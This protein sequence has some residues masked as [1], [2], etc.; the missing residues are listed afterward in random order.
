[1]L[2]QY[3]YNAGTSS[4]EWSATFECR[5]DGAAWAPCPTGYRPAAPLADGDHVH[6]GQLLL[7]PDRVVVADR[8]DMSAVGSQFNCVGGGSHSWP[9]STT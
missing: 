4:Q 8:D 9:H 6:V 1:M 7:D 2:F 3:A 5:L